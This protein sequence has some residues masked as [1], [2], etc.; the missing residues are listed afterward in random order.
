MERTL[1]TQSQV[2]VNKNH[3]HCI[4]RLLDVSNDKIYRFHQIF[5]RSY[6]GRKALIKQFYAGHRL[7]RSLASFRT[8]ASLFQVSPI[9][10]IPHHPRHR[11]P[12]IPGLCS[13]LSVFPCE[14]ISLSPLHSA[15][16]RGGDCSLFEPKYARRFLLSPNTAC[17]IS[18]MDCPSWRLTWLSRRSYQSWYGSLCG[19]LWLRMA[20][21]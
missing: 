13:E 3:Y 20:C 5:Q 12:R 9:P 15:L 8:A 21:T 14:I 17:K 2:V 16:P 1:C 7:W 11:Q 4:Y 6:F 18:Q 10:K 19:P